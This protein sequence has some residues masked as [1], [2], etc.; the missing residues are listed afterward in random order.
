MLQVPRVDV[1]A[2]DGVLEVGVGSRDGRVSRVGRGKLLEGG[3]LVGIECNAFRV[4][5]V[6]KSYSPR[7]HPLQ[8]FLRFQ[9]TKMEC[10]SRAKPSIYSDR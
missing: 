4:T 2:V 6:L 8:L 10:D 1:L 9:E 3:K 5:R 7:P